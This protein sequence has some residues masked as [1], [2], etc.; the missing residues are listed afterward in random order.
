MLRSRALLCVVGVTLTGCALTSRYR[1]TSNERT[2]YNLL[3]HAETAGACYEAGGAVCMSTDEADAY[4]TLRKSGYAAGFFRRLYAEAETEA[5]LLWAYIGLCDL[6]ANYAR[7]VE[8]YRVSEGDSVSVWVG[9]DLIRLSVAEA[10]EEV[11]QSRPWYLVPRD[12]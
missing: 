5:G 10:I 6:D 8:Q 3:M 7:Y 2:A 11:K 4:R 1:A 9:H 12:W